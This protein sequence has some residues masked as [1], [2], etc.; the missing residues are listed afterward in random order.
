MRNRES[1]GDV[2]VGEKK[3]RK[4]KAEVVRYNQERLIGERTV[5]GGRTTPGQIEES[6]N[7]RRP[8]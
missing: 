3:E 6:H 4:T 5:S 8:T 2:G 1:D 7:T